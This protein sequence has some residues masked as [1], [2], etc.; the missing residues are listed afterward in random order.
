ML[1]VPVKFETKMS[2]ENKLLLDAGALNDGDFGARS[3][4]HSLRPQTGCSLSAIKL[5]TACRH[6]YLRNT[7]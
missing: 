6:K 7:K 5:H 3:V 4:H 1:A 2:K